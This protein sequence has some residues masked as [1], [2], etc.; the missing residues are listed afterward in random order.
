VMIGAPLLLLSKRVGQVVD[1]MPT[2]WPIALAVGAAA[3][4]LHAKPRF[5]CWRPG[6][7][8]SKRSGPGLSRRLADQI[9]QRGRQSG[10]VDRLAAQ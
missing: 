8:M 7:A 2:T 3:A 4:V 5:Y 10:G 1:A 9:R 6:L